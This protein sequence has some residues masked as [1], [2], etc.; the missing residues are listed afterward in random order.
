MNPEDTQFP[1]L[2]CTNQNADRYKYLAAGTPTS[3]RKPN[4]FFA[5]DL[6]QCV[7]ILPRLI[8]SIVETI[9][10]L[11]P[12]NCALSIVEGRSTDGT[13]EVL[14]LLANK[15]QDL[16]VTYY[17]DSN[18]IA[19]SDDRISR[20]AT[21]RNLALQPLID[22]KAQ[23]SEDTTVIF[24][25]DVAICAEDILELVH[26]RVH[27][28]ADMTCAMDWTYVGEHPTFYDV[29]IGRGMSG[30]TFFQIPADGS[31]DFAWNLFW[32]DDKARGRLQN[33]KPF[34]VF[35]CWNG[36][37]VFTA[38]PILDEMVRFRVHADDECFQGEPV[39]FCK[40]MWYH[41][42]RKIAVV[43]S[44]NLEYSD[45]DAT[46]IKEYKGYVPRW[47]SNDGL[48]DR[49]DWESAPPA[50]LKCMP[51]YDSQTWEPWDK[52]LPRVNSTY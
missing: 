45:K 18:D 43:P 41:G 48:D 21:L 10:F 42:Y 2:K 17:F 39:L 20:L 4:Y 47:I 23:F 1:R 5:L 26:Q 14:A 44:V 8:G 36:A 49:I 31:W 29:W 33:G 27:Q 35:S 46:R 13:F 38:K 28:S 22:N 24:L 12:H 25:N 52:G 32:N 9:R 3:S 7:H 19:P 40:D 6:T 11:G 34:Q 37:A 51:N 15:L 30:D 50:M 16:G